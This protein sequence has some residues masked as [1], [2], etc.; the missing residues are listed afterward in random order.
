[1][2]ETT[3]THKQ[4]QTMKH[5]EILAAIKK[6]CT[7]NGC[8]ELAGYISYSWNGRFTRRLGDANLRTFHIRLST[9]LWPRA[10]D[11]TRYETVVHEACHLIAFHKHKERGHGY[12]W[13]ACMARTG[14][15]PERCHNVDR[16]G[17]ARTQK[18]ATA[19]CGCGECTLGPVRAKKLAKN[20]A[21]YACRRCGQFITLAPKKV[22]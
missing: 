16:T 19:Y 14:T 18:R 12:A 2:W 8:P 17:L 22:G 6:A 21:R 15:K 3:N 13:K 9:P 4:G 7:D 5:T 20:Q 11:A 10:N 1:M